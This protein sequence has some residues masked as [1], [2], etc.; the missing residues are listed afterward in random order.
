M[1][2]G[3]HV[4]APGRRPVPPVRRKRV[5]RRV[6]IDRPRERRSDTADVCFRCG[7]A[8]GAVCAWLGLLVHEIELP[9]PMT[10]GQIV[11]LG[12]AKI[13]VLLMLGGAWLTV[14]SWNRSRW[15]QGI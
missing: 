14:K 8:L 6:I 10:W 2:E 13:P 11:L 1:A 12:V 9:G 5:R 3:A 15:G 7:V 4:P